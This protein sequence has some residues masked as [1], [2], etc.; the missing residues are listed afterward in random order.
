[1]KDL[2]AF[3]DMLTAD[4]PTKGLEHI[5]ENFRMIEEIRSWVIDYI[6]NHDNYVKTAAIET[7]A[8]LDAQEAVLKLIENGLKTNSST[9]GENGKEALEKQAYHTHR[10]ANAMQLLLR[11]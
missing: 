2:I 9:L 4:D 5:A 11:S 10:C 6:K 8:L 7:I 3:E 1:M